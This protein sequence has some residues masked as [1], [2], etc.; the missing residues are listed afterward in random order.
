MIQEVKLALKMEQ[1]YKSTQTMFGAA[2]PEKIQWFKDMLLKWA[3]KHDKPILEA[4]IDILELPQT[5]GDGFAQ[6]FF[7]AAA[8]DLIE[9]EKRS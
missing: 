6:C 7:T 3:V 8:F 4:L 2:Y 1:C 9:I 5:V